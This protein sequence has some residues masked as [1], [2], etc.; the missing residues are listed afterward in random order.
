MLGE[1]KGRCKHLV[2]LDAD[3]IAI[4]A[5]HPLT[6]NVVLIGALSNFL[7]LDV[8]SLEESVSNLVPPKTV[9]VNLKAFR[10]G[11]ETSLQAIE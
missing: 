8:G 4:E 11:R 9:E 10:L 5:G 6:A 2:P 1:L 7:P 3:K